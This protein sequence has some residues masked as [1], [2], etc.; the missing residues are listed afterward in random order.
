MPITRH[1][2]LLQTCYNE[3]SDFP[4]E[5]QNTLSYENGLCMKNGHSF[6]A[7]IKCSNGLKNILQKTEWRIHPLRDNKYLEMK[8]IY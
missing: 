2:L 6:N 4:A 5:V 7:N 3:R 8:I 1:A